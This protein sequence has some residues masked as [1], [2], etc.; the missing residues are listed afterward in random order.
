MDNYS[1]ELYLIMESEYRKRGASNNGAQILS[2]D[3]HLK[4]MVSKYGE[5]KVKDMILNNFDSYHFLR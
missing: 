1:D 5:E 2:R 3:N 4:F